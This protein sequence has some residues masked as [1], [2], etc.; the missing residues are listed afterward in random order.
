MFKQF[1]HYD[2]TIKVGDGR[3][4]QVKGIGTVEI[5]TRGEKRKI[6]IS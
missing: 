2:S 1:K 5:I 6:V 3:Q 4:L